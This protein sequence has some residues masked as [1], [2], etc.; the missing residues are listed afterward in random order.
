MNRLAAAVFAVLALAPPAFAEG[1]EATDV[2]A[3]LREALED[4]AELP[5]LPPSLPDTA[6]PR[7]RQPMPDQAFGAKGAAEKAAHEEAREKATEVSERARAD[8]EA[9]RGNGGNGTNA[10]R[11]ASDGSQGAANQARTDQG[12]GQGKGGNGNGNG[13]GGS[14]NG[15]GGNGGGH[16]HPKP[17]QR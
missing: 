16:G 7:A 15:G 4:R 3:A 10:A 6:G 11:G 2:R 9:A 13:N 5:R 14:G 8:G 12:R 17:I 1:A